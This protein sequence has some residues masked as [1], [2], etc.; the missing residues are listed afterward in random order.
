M[1]EDLKS[2]ILDK[3]RFKTVTL[4]DFVQHLRNNDNRA[5]MRMQSEIIPSELKIK[6]VKSINHTKNK[7]EECGE[8]VDNF[9]SI[10]S[11]LHKE[12]VIKKKGRTLKDLE[13]ILD[14]L[15]ENNHEEINEV[16]GIRAIFKTAT[17]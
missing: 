12:T 8:I 7:N 16:D 1:K 3:K 9:V 15:Q 4:K 5:K 6:F 14:K 11:E 2:R 17:I 13:N 10:I